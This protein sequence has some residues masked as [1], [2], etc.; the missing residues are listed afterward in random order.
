MSETQKIHSNV[1]TLLGLLLPEE[2]PIGLKHCCEFFIKLIWEL[3]QC[4]GHYI[5]FIL[6][7]FVCPA[8][9]QKV[10]CAHSYFFVLCELFIDVSS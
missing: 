10:G 3:K 1:S 9:G 7:Y 6:Y 5:S 2:N 4:C 8:S